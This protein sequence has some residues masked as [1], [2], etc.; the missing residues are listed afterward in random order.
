[1]VGALRENVP[2][3]ILVNASSQHIHNLLV[4]ENDLNRCFPST[5]KVMS[6]HVLSFSDFQITGG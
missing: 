2:P 3:L 6:K 5:R 1:M 4:N